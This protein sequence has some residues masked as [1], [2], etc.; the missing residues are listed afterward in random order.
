M[1]A[2]TLLTMP[3]PT[4]TIAKLGPLRFETGVRRRNAVT[5]FYAAF[6][7]VPMAIYLAFVQ[8]YILNEVLHIPIERQ[9]AFTGLLQ[10]LAE[11]VTIFTFPIA[12]ALSDRLGRRVIYTFGF[13]VMA[14]GY[15][16]YPL[17][18]SEGQLVLF[19]M[20]FA[21]GS[22]IS[23]TMLVAIITDYISE[24]S[25]GKWVAWTNVCQSIGIT[26]MALLLVPSPKGWL[27]LGFSSLEAARYAYWT[28]A[29]ICL[30]SAAIFWLG[31]RRDR[32]E[33]AVRSNDIIGNLQK[34]V[35][36]A[37]VNP[38]IAIVYASAFVGR[39]DLVVIGT[40]LSLWVVKIGTEHDLS[41]AAGLAR[42]AVLFGGATLAGILWA[43]IMGWIIDRVARLTAFCIAYALAALSYF[44]LSQI[45]DP[46]SNLAIPAVI[47]IGISETSVIVA[48]V[49]FLGQEAPKEIR[50]AV[51]GVNNLVGSLGVIFAGYVGGQLFDL[52]MP[53]GPFAM[54]AILN[55]LLFL[56]AFMVRQRM[57]ETN[58]V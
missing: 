10:S 24:A 19:R 5:V 34:G 46:F 8:P 36:L 9:G 52:W 43:P 51:I 31:L 40:F 13:L 32:S 55:I 38:R 17:A 26:A 45:G 30:G 57:P 54:M 25:R 11:I 1:N 58:A 14:L 53:T 3:S 49:S 20:V 6:V 18:G 22:G 23:L 44:S 47:L 48:N 12:G 41:T 39:G 4:E 2:L 7:S 56:A 16:L 15:L 42:A 37:L 50:G 27:S 28:G 33:R 21:I 29:L 35:S